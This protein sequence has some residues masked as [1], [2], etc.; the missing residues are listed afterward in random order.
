MKVFD[1]EFIA[2]V[3]KKKGPVFIKLLL[4]LQTPLNTHSYIHLN[5]IWSEPK[6]EGSNLL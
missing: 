4:S 1:K 2:I 5:K 6:S 3:I